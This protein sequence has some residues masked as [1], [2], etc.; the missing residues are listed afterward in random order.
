[1]SSLGLV[2]ESDSESEGGFSSVQKT[3]Q[4]SGVERPE[5]G[6]PEVGLLVLGFHFKSV[7]RSKR[8][9][10]VGRALTQRMSGTIGTVEM[11][12]GAT[13]LCSS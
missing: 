12:N 11:N 8:K 13:L 3:R 1:M 2:G 9:I 5:V 10:V 6:R 4:L 7:D